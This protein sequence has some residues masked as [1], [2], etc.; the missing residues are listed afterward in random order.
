MM[1]SYLGKVTISLEVPDK[2][3]SREITVLITIFSSFCSK[4][5]IFTVLGLL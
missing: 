5:K 1:D 3:S 2:Q 4:L